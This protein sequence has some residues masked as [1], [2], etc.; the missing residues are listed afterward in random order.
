MPKLL[1]FT[2]PIKCSYKESRTNPALY[3]LAKEDAKKWKAKRVACTG[4][5][6]GSDYIEIRKLFD[7][8]DHSNVLIIVAKDGWNLSQHESR[9][10]DRWGRSTQGL[11]VRISMNN[12][13]RM[14]FEEFEEM[15]AAIAEAKDILGV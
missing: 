2:K 1:D 13:A 3:D 7:S 9:K 12:P 8:V 5:K 10:P 4:G 6:N 15:N 14:T 11:N